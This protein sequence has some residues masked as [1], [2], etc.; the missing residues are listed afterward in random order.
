M[1]TMTTIITV[2]DG[3]LGK[4]LITVEL[5][6]TLP[7]AYVQHFVGR[8]R[9]ICGRRRGC[10]DDWWRSV[11]PRRRS[12]P[13]TTELSRQRNR[14]PSSTRWRQPSRRTRWTSARR[15]PVATTA[16]ACRVRSWRTR[17]PPG[18]A[19]PPAAAGHLPTRRGGRS[20][21]QHRVAAASYDNDDDDDDD[22]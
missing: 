5:W 3:V 7:R 13:T 22:D 8:P 20:T 1:M 14:T 19:P 9:A 17:P 21:S 11:A 15:A 12:P 4:L 10:S 18:R 2:T 16:S 6:R